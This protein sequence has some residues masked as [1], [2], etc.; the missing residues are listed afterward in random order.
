MG[1]YLTSVSFKIKISYAS[2]KH[3]DQ[4]FAYIY[5]SPSTLVYDN[6]FFYFSYGHHEIIVS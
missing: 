2:V 3:F 5:T 6:L 4:Y 1:L